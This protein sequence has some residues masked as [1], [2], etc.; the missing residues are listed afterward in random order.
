M[1][2]MKAMEEQGRAEFEAGALEKLEALKENLRSYENA[3]VAFS[4]GVDS[5]F[6]AYKAH[7]VL[8][9]R[10][11]AVTVSAPSFPARELAE[12]E[13]FCKKYGIKHIVRGFDQLSVKGFA[14]NPPDRC[15]HCKKG[16]FAVITEAAGESGI[17]TVAEGS[18][19]DDMSDFRPGL[20]AIKELGVR[21]P[22]REAGLTKSN[23][24][25]L[26]RQ[27]GLPTWNKP[28]FACL[29]SRIPYGDSIT[30]GKLE[31]IDKA[32]QKL[33]ELG[34]TQYRVRLHGDIAR[35][36]LPQE[37]FGLILSPE[38][39]GCINEYFRQLGFAYTALDLG[40]YRT[41]SMNR[42]LS[43]STKQSYTV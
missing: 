22:L 13:G 27:H 36:E 26:S 32:E 4:A 12:A 14:D 16:I 23:I 17:V 20:K 41:G 15:Y 29:A 24:R 33:S 2:E 34:F 8:G 18:N 7:E 42:Q 21:S 35:I 40:G 28:S 31:M 19:L 11:A 1:D 39:R 5:A 43:E 9:S 37:E 25:E 30:S 10:M 38:T 6:L 3:I